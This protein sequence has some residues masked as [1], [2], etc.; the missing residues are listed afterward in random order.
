MVYLKISER[1]DLVEVQGAY[2]EEVEEGNVR[3]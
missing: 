1:L 2:R 3:I